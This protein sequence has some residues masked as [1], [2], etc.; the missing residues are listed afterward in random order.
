VA[1]ARPIV[2]WRSTS[3]S[4]GLAAAYVFVHLLPE[5]ARGNQQVASMP[6]TARSL[7]PR[8]CSAAMIV[9]NTRARR[10]LASRLTGP[11]GGLEKLQDDLGD[12]GRAATQR[13][14][15]AVP[16]RLRRTHRR[17]QRLQR[18]HRL[19]RAAQAADESRAGRRVLRD[20]RCLVS[21]DR[22][23]RNQFPQRL[24]GHPHA[25]LALSAGAIGGWV[26]ALLVPDTTLTLTLLAAFLG[27]AVLLNVLDEELPARHVCGWRG[28]RWAS[29]SR[30]RH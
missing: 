23:L 10:R 3:L 24:A 19:S 2:L 18:L 11:R 14:Q 30:R 21:T 16:S 5:L 6:G 9:A 25:R 28:S 12:A 27:G 8:T 26:R 17:L 15:T 20:S 22:L 7:G 29:S 4:G 13:W 1:H